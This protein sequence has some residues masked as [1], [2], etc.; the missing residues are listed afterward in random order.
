MV[1]VLAAPHRLEDRVREAE[2]Q[3][4]LDRLLAEVVVDAEDLV[5]GEL[6]VHEP[7]QLARGLPAAAER[8]LDD[9]AHPRHDLGVA[10]AHDHLLPRQ[11]LHDA[12]V[13]ARG[14]REVGEAPP[15]HRLLPLP[16]LQA[17]AQRAIRRGVV[18]VAAQVEQ[19]PGEAGEHRLVH[20]S[21]L[22]RL[23]EA[24]LDRLPERLLA[25]LLA[26]DADHGEALGHQLVVGQV[27]EGG[28]QLA[29]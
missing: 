14:N 11:V 29:V 28:H 1:D 26:G 23:R 27:E 10:D 24:P 13:Q 18:Q 17:L 12:R 22:L 6:L 19:A 7:V 3:D 16:L 25:L 15:R 8:L 2:D 20:R 5:L 4:V 21:R 9:D